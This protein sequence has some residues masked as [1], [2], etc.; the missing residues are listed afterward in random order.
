MNR[1]K[2]KLN[3]PN[4]FKTKLINKLKKDFNTFSKII[5]NKFF[6]NKS[7]KINEPKETRNKYGFP[8]SK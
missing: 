2:T 8:I 7:G 1:Q 4:C 6:N 5:T 3:K